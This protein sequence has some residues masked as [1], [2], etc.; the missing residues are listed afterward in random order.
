M[1][2]YRNI[3]IYEVGKSLAAIVMIITL[4]ICFFLFPMFLREIDAIWMALIVTAIVGAATFLVF[5]N[6]EFNAAPEATQEDQ[7]ISL[8]AAEHAI[9]QSKINNFTNFI[10]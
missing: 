3:G 10:T 7:K 5:I 6:H 1:S 2:L 4:V 9:R 8:Q